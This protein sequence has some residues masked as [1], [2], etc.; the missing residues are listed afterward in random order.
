MPR[1]TSRKKPF[2]GKAKKQQ[3]SAKR[4]RKRLEKQRHHAKQ[5][6]EKRLDRERYTDATA[7]D[8]GATLGSTPNGCGGDILDR[9][10][11]ELVT[12]FGGSIRGNRLSTYFYRE[13]DNE[14]NRRRNDAT[15]PL[16]FQPCR[17]DGSFS[18]L[19]D[20]SLGPH[21]GKVSDEPDIGAIEKP[22][23]KDNYIE[24]NHAEEKANG[25]PSD[26]QHEPGNLSAKISV[27]PDM[28]PAPSTVLDLTSS[29]SQSLAVPLSDT[30]PRNSEV[31][32]K[33]CV[34]SE[35]DHP[36]RPPWTPSMSKQEVEEQEERYFSEWAAKI[37]ALEGVEVT[38]FELNLEVWRQLWRVCEFSDAILLVADVRY[39]IFHIP[40]S[41][42]RHLRLPMHT[43]S[44]G[45]S[46]AI[47]RPPT[48]VIVLNKVDLVSEAHV[49][50]WTAYLKKVYPDV[51]VVPFSSKPPPSEHRGKGGLTN[52]RRQLKKKYGK[53]T[54]AAHLNTSVR[55]ILAA[56]M[57]E[58]GNG[59]RL[60]SIHQNST[61]EGR[62]FSIGLIGQPNTGK[63]SLLNAI[64]GRKVAST[65]RTAGHTKHLQHILI[66]YTAGTD[67]SFGRDCLHLPPAPPGG[68][69][70]IDCPG[71]VF[72]RAVPRCLAEILGMHP[73]AQVR[74]PFTAIRYLAERIPLEKMYKLKMPDWYDDEDIES[75]LKDPSHSRWTPQAIAEALAEQKG[76]M[77]GKGGIP[78]RQR[79]GLEILR[80]TVDGI[81]LLAFKPPRC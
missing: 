66:E 59:E 8:D 63:T 46:T 54:A 5:Q 70:L 51:E 72:P 73:L 58:I 45:S 65:S 38:P 49:T 48:L 4:E 57:R 23:P 80:D 64:S 69:F 67:A 15:R 6:Q 53:Q 33:N 30:N 52:R 9:S 7:S 60:D 12:S 39:P 19:A 10:K 13:S 68:C 21:I 41:L 18:P 43:S 27:S 71:L 74:E 76:Y 37:H 25:L 29:M 61:E 44:E 16:C 75:S 2:S 42:V 77:I 11:G 14:V 34:H 40:P 3:L 32:K 31:A 1:K 47:P 22:D 24:E 35:L 17:L 79:A 36:V 50:A 56:A 62:K 81:V 26:K 20:E 78:D 28:P 55:R